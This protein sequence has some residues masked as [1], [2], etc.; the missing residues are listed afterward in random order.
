MS[1][2]IAAASL[3]KPLPPPACRPPCR[4]RRLSG[5]T[6]GTCRVRD[7]M[8]RAAQDA[9]ASLPSALSAPSPARSV[10]GIV[11]VSGAVCRRCAPMLQL[12]AIAGALSAPSPIWHGVPNSVTRAV[13]SRCFVF[14]VLSSLSCQVLCAQTPSQSIPLPP[15]GTP[16][17]AWR[18]EHHT[19]RAPMQSAVQS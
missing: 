7:L 19:A 5:I 6:S 17:R 1:R 3:R 14:L 11:A 18:E 13:G 12:L 4:R 2:A 15:T 10:S 8:S 16:A 9:A